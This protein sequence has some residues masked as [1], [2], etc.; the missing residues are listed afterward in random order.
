[1]LKLTVG[2]KTAFDARLRAEDVI[3]ACNVE[4]NIP[5]PLDRDEATSFVTQKA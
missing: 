5:A 3:N 4:W 1:L 2:V